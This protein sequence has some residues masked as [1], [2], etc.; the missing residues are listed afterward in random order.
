MIM[1][2]K[3]QYEA[4][5]AQIGD[6]TVFGRNSFNCSLRGLVIGDKSAIGSDISLMLHERITIGQ[7]VVINS[8]VQLLTGSHS[9]KDP[10]WLMYAKPI[11][12]GDYA[13]I[14][15]GAIILPGVTIGK[16]A[17][18]G[19]GAVV[20]KDVSEFSI[21][22]GNPAKV[23]GERVRDLSYSPVDFCA[24]FEAWLGNKTK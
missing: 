15:S 12:I 10:N 9:T 22:V 5:G 16:G 11:T 24:P 20:S 19:A 23:V 8:Y 6:F 7:R 17:V 3:V 1:F 21:V 2:R 13:W 18:I 4:R 14:A